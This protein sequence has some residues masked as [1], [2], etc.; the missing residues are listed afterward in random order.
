MEGEGTGERTGERVGESVD[1]MAEDSGGNG[2]ADGSSK[3]VT[4]SRGILKSENESEA[5]EEG[6]RACRTFS[7]EGWPGAG[8]RA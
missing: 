2:I 3:A 8:R 4:R 1:E 7:C 6:P 5:R